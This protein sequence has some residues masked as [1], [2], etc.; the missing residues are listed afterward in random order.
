MQSQ[1]FIQQYDLA[2]VNEGNGFR[3]YSL[4]FTDPVLLSIA[5]LLGVRYYLDVLGRRHQGRDRQLVMHLETFIVRGVN[6]ALCDPI[7][8][9]SDQMLIAVALCAAYEVKHG[10]QRSYHMHMNGLVRMIS[11]R[12]GLHTI[13]AVDENVARLLLW[14]DTNASKIAG[15]DCYLQEIGHSLETACRPLPQATPC[16]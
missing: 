15:S 9:I 16:C 5:V 8:G 1:D 7:R 2:D 6:D 11:L 14:I 13:E 4:V 10:S 12:R 3:L